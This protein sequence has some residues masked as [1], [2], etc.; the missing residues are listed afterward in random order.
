MRRLF[1]FSIVLM[2]PVLFLLGCGKQSESNAKD[3]VETY[4]D[5]VK[6]GDLKQYMYISSQTNEFYD[7]F[8]YEYLSTLEEN[9]IK[10]EESDTR[11]EFDAFYNSITDDTYPSPT[12]EENM[13]RVQDR[14]GDDNDFIV[15]SDEDGFEVTSKEKDFK[16]YKFLYNTEIANATGSKIYKKVEFTVEYQYDIWNGKEY[17]EGFVI[18][19][20]NIR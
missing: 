15:D 19:K 13:E 5:L 3:A 18:K 8:D 2:L 11:D 7:V 14:F 20:L 1:V 12:W 17:T 4:M 9:D 16:Q 10:Y 6:E